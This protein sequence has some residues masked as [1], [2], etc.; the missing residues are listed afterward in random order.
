L[1]I[2]RV[3]VN[4]DDYVPWSVSTSNSSVARVVINFAI[5]R[6]DTW[7]LFNASVAAAL[8]ARGRLEAHR[9]DPDDQLHPISPRRDPCSKTLIILRK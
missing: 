3:L 5:S 2:Y 8:S 1:Y 7:C 4:K 6:D 9:P